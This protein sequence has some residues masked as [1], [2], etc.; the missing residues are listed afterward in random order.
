MPVIANRSDLRLMIGLLILVLLA[1][2]VP[3]YLYYDYD[4][5]TDEQLV[6]VKGRMK[7]W[8][9]N[10]L[11][12]R[13]DHAPGRRS[14]LHIRIQE[15]DKLYVV[16]E[17]IYHSSAKFNAAGFKQEVREGDELVFTVP[18]TELASE[19]YRDV[20]G[21]SSQD[22]TYLAVEHVSAD[23][24]ASHRKMLFIT[25][26]MLIVCPLI[27]YALGREIRRYLAERSGQA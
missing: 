11:G 2:A 7:D 12:R 19:L 17:D 1:P 6:Q 22:V 18:R 10:I 15:D 24:E 21:L 9:E 5:I 25:L 8:K 4:P 26:A 13:R 23:D 20:Y 14:D 27:G 3:G 16:R